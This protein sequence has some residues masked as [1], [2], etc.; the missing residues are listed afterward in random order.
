MF[1][2]GFQENEAIAGVYGRQ[3]P[4]QSSNTDNMRD[5]LFL[6]VKKAS[7]ILKNF[8]SIMQIV[9]LGLAIFATIN[10]MKNFTH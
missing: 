4:M 2:A 8:F 5:L 3:I 9:Q 10:L 6:L 7:L 1:I